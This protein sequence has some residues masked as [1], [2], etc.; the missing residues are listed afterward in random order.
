[1]EKNRALSYVPR[2]IL[3][4]SRIFLEFSTGPK[5]SRQ[6]TKSCPYL[7]EM[8]HFTTIFLYVPPMYFIYPFITFNSFGK[9]KGE[10]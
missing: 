3:A 7:S 8:D 10:T 4:R 5:M 6:A 1:M 9:G 2:R